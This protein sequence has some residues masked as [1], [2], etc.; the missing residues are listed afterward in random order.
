MTMVT[1][2]RPEE[3]VFSKTTMA[4]FEGMPVT[5]DHPDAEEGVTV[6]NV[7]WLSKG[8]CQ[9]VRR[10]TG[11]ESNMLIVDLVITDPKTIQDVLDGKRK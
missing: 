8:H 2:Y 3:E 10:G 7:Q 4:S 9:N 5:N 1:V 11:N 6:D